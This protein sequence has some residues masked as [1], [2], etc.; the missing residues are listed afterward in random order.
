MITNI[1]DKR[2]H[3]YRWVKVNAVIEPTAHDNSIFDAD[4][5]Q[6]NAPDWIGYDER[7]HIS[8]AAAFDWAQKHKEFVTLFLYDEDGGT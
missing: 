2:K 6:H 1:I 8:V 3:P 4:F 7:E 5:I